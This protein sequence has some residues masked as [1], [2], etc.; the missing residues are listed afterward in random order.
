MTLPGGKSRRSGARRRRD[1][2]ARERKLTS[3][4]DA[5]SLATD[6]SGEE[7]VGESWED[8]EGTV[9]GEVGFRL[10]VRG[11]AVA[12]SDA[13][14]GELE[15]EMLENVAPLN[16]RLTTRSVPSRRSSWEAQ[17]AR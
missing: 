8:L 5:S 11:E 1:K 9:T 14:A 7:V 17:T 4:S 3:T 2:A 12:L 6:E 15:E 10:G 13:G 16:D